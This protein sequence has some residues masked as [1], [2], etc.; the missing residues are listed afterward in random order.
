MKKLLHKIF[1]VKNKDIYKV[2]TILG[3]EFKIKS[4]KLENKILGSTKEAA[5]VI[6][7]A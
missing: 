4:K 3:L 2:I 6:K 7:N 5:E 1:S